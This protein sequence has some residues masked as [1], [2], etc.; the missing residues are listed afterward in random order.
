[1]AC[2]KLPHRSNSLKHSRA[3]VDGLEKVPYLPKI[4]RR[5]SS[6]VARKGGGATHPG[7]KACCPAQRSTTLLASKT[8][9]LST[10]LPRTA[11]KELHKRAADWE[12]SGGRDAGARSTARLPEATTPLRQNVTTYASTALGP[13]AD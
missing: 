13:A 1:M 10:R 8:G 4:N 3:L 12:K 9:L 5:K 11:G 6:S 7:P 2:V